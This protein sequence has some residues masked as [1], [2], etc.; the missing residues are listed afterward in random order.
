M[1]SQD[2]MNFDPSTCTMPAAFFAAREQAGPLSAMEHCYRNI[3]D[4]RFQDLVQC[5][6][7]M[8][9]AQLTSFGERWLAPVVRAIYGSHKPLPTGALDW[10]DAYH[11][12]RQ[13]A[14]EHFAQWNG[15]NARKTPGSVP[16]QQPLLRQS[17]SAAQY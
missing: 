2:M 16:G 7:V 11:K 1:N 3:G 13:V 10:I 12:A 14:L 8:G 6:S 9:C 15:R 5:D 17:A 4:A